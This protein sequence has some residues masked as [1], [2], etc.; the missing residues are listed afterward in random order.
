MSAMTFGYTAG[1]AL[2]WR[3][4]V[5]PSLGLWASNGSPLVPASEALALVDAAAVTSSPHPD[6]LLIATVAFADQ[7]AAKLG[8]SLQPN[9]EL[10]LLDPELGRTLHRAFALG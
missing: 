7:V 1:A 6:D 3:G 8:A 5:G 10:S 4:V 9:P 2:L